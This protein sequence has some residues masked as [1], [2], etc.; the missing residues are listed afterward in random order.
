M[1]VLDYIL[2]GI[3]VFFA[4]L[5]LIRGLVSQLFSIL[6]LVAG[7]LAARAYYGKLAVYLGLQ[8]YVGGFS[9]FLL[10]FIAGFICARLLGLLVEKLMKTMKLSLFNRV[11]GFLLGL[12]KGFAICALIIAGMLLVYPEGEKVVKSSPAASYFLRA[13]R[14][15]YRVIPDDIKGR[16]EAEPGKVME[17]N[18][19]PPATP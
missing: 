10:I 8:K 9:A 17:K 6:G 15:I 1:S 14:A 18:D 3:L 13:G 12:L 4:F 2:I 7:F 5:G 11:C 19:P 16:K